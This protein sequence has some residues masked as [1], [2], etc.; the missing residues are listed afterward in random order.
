MKV[1]FFIDGVN[2]TKSGEKRMINE[3]VQ[4][5]PEHGACSRRFNV[6]TI[7]YH[8][9]Y[10]LKP[11]QLTSG[12]AAEFNKSKFNIRF[13]RAD[14]VMRNA[15]CNLVSHLAN[16][17][18]CHTCIAL[19]VSGHNFD[20]HSLDAALRDQESWLHPVAEGSTFLGRKGPAPLLLLRG[21][22]I[23]DMLPIDPMHN[24]FLGVGDLLINTL[25]LGDSA[26]GGKK[27]KGQIMDEVNDIYCEHRFP[28][29]IPRKPRPIEPKWKASEFKSFFLVCGHR[30][31][32][33]FAK[34]D[35][36][37]IAKIIARFTYMLRAILLND[38]WLAKVTEKVSL[39]DLAFQQHKELREA[40][41]INNCNLNLHNFRHLIDWRGK[42]RLFEVSAEPGEAYF[43]ENKRVLETRNRHYGK[44]LHYNRCFKELAGH[45]CQPT[46]SVIPEA[47]Q[48]HSSRDNAM[49]INNEMQVFK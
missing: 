11:E 45:W 28:L 16:N 32:E 6:V 30:I 26:H 40:I 19:P 33:V 18:S 38:S 27:L 3:V 49:F 48:K 25:I 10:K 36:D 43:G 35:L 2:P 37:H 7:T 31:A 42:T 5:I 9:K 24:A 34:Y 14:T 41:G 12:L 22:K 8:Q 4:F 15:L 1:D 46:F 17:Y 29:E 44:Q 23:P 13:I 39:Q 20:E 47:V 21:Y